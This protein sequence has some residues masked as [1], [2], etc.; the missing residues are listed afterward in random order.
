M[1]AQLEAIAAEYFAPLGSVESRKNHAST[2]TTSSGKAVDR[3][4]KFGMPLGIKLTVDLPW[5]GMSEGHCTY[6]G[7]GDNSAAISLALLGRFHFLPPLLQYFSRIP[8]DD[9]RSHTNCAAPFGI[10][11][12]VQTS[13][14]GSVSM[15]CD[16]MWQRT[17]QFGSD[18]TD[19][20]LTAHRGKRGRRE[21]EKQATLPIGGHVGG[22]GR[23]RPSNKDL[24]IG[25]DS[26]DIFANFS[27]P[28]MSD[29][30]DSYEMLCERHQRGL[31]AITALV[32][33]C[34][35][36]FQRE[37]RG[38]AA[39]ATAGAGF[40]S[41]SRPTPTLTHYRNSIVHSLNNLLRSLT[42][43]GDRVLALHI[44]IRVA[45]WKFSSRN[46]RVTILFNHISACLPTSHS[47][48]ATLAMET[49]AQLHAIG[50]SSSV[51]LK[52]ATELLRLA[53]NFVS[54][55]S[56]PSV[57]ASGYI[58]IR[59]IAQWPDLLY[60]ALLRGM[61]DDLLLATW[62]SLLNDALEPRVRELGAVALRSLFMVDIIQGHYSS[63]REMLHHA[64]SL[65]RTSGTLSKPLGSNVND[66]SD[67]DRAARTLPCLSVGGV[68]RPLEEGKESSS[69][70]PEPN[71]GVAGVSASEKQTNTQN[72]QPVRWIRRVFE[73][74]GSQVRAQSLRG[75]QTPNKAFD[76]VA[77]IQDAAEGL[78]P[79]TTI[80]VTNSV[81][82]N[83]TNGGN[84]FS[85][86]SSVPRT[87]EDFYFGTLLSRHTHGRNTRLD[88]RLGRIRVLCSSSTV[89]HASIL[90][91][92]ALVSALRSCGDSQ[93][94]S[95]AD[96]SDGVLVD[97]ALGGE[98]TRE[99][100]PGDN[101]RS[102]SWSST[103]PKA[104]SSLS[105]VLPSHHS[106]DRPVAPDASLSAQGLQTG[107]EESPYNASLTQVPHCGGRENTRLRG[108]E[109]NPQRPSVQEPALGEGSPTL[110]DRSW[111][112]EEPDLWRLFS[113]RVLLLQCLM[114]AER[115]TEAE[116]LHAARLIPSL[117]F[118]SLH[119]LPKNDVYT[120]LGILLKRV[121]LCYAEH[122]HE[123]QRHDGRTQYPP[124][125]ACRYT[126][127][128]GDKSAM[129]NLAYGEVDIYAMSLINFSL[130]LSAI[131]TTYSQ[132][133][134]YF[135]VNHLYPILF[136]ALQ[137]GS[138]TYCS[139]SNEVFALLVCNIPVKIR[140]RL[141]PIVINLTDIS[142]SMPFSAEM[143]GAVAKICTV[144]RGI[145]THCCFALL[146]RIAEVLKDGDDGPGKDANHFTGRSG[147]D[148]PDPIAVQM[149]KITNL[150]K[151]ILC[152]RVLNAVCTDWES[153]ALF[154]LE[155]CTPYLHHPNVVLRRTCVQSCVRLLLS[156]C[157]LSK[158]EQ[159]GGNP[160]SGAVDD[161][162]EKATSCA[163]HYIHTGVLNAH[164]PLHAA[165]T[166]GYWSER[167]GFTKSG[168][169]IYPF[170]ASAFDN[171]SRPAEAN[172]T[173]GSAW[174]D[175]GSG[176]GS[177]D[178]S[179]THAPEIGSAGAAGHSLM[180]TCERH[181]G[182]SH[183]T[184]L[185]EVLH[186]LVV[187]AL[188]DPDETIRHTALCS[189]TKD[190]DQFLYPHKEVIDLIFS[191]INDE[192]PPSRLEAVRI[193]R[194]LGHYVPMDVY[195]RLRKRFLSM[196][197]D[198]QS[199]SALARVQTA[200]DS[201]QQ[202]ENAECYSNAPNPP[203]QNLKQGANVGSVVGT[204]DS[205]EMSGSAKY[206]A[207]QM[208]LLFELVQSVSPYIST[209]ID[210][211]LKLL[212]QVIVPHDTLERGTVIT[213]LHMIS[214]L[215]DESTR[216]EWPKF[217]VLLKPLSQQLLLRD[218]DVDRL[219]MAISTLQ[220][221]IQYVVIASPFGW[222][223]DLRLT[224]GSLYS[225]LY[226]KPPIGTELSLS[227]VKLLGTISAIDSDYQRDDVQSA[228]LFALATHNVSH[229]SLGVAA[230][231][232]HLPVR[233]LPS[234]I[235]FSQT[236]F[237][238]DCSQD[239]RGVSAQR[240]QLTDHLWPDTIL[241]V[242]LQTL[243]E[244]LDN[245]IA[246]TDEEL[247]A[248][249]QATV[250][251]L[252][253][254]PS[255]AKLQLYMPPLLSVLAGLL[256]RTD[257]DAPLRVS[258][259]ES[260][261]D[262]VKL[263]GRGSAPM[264]GFLVTF[265]NEHFMS[266]SYTLP[267]C[268]R[269]LMAL[270]EAVPD[271][272]RDHC[273]WF[274]SLLLGKLMSH[275]E[276]V[277]LTS[278]DPCALKYKRQQNLSTSAGLGNAH[279]LTVRDTA[280]RSNT[281][282]SAI[283]VVLEAVLALLPIAD[284]FTVHYACLMLSQ[285]LR[286]AGGTP[287]PLGG[288]EGATECHPVGFDYP[289]GLSI[290]VIRDI[291]QVLVD[292]LHNFDLTA[293]AVSVVES[294]LVLLQ[295]YEEG[296]AAALQNVTIELHLGRMLEKS[297]SC[298]YLNNFQRP[299]KT[300]RKR[301]EK[302][303][304]D[305]RGDQQ[306]WFRHSPLSRLVVEE[307][308]ADGKNT[309]HRFPFRD[310]PTAWESPLEMDLL[311][312]V[313]LVTGRCRLPSV[314]YD[315]MI[316]E[317]IETR[318]Q[319]CPMVKK[320]FNMVASPK[321]SLRL[322]PRV[323]EEG[324][325]SAA[326]VA[327]CGMVSAS[328][329]VGGT[330][331]LDSHE[332]RVST[333]AMLERHP[334]EELQRICQSFG[335]REIKGKSFPIP[336]RKIHLP[337]SSRSSL[338]SSPFPIQTTTPKRDSSGFTHKQVLHT[339]EDIAEVAYT[340]N[341]SPVK[342]YVGKNLPTVIVPGSGDDSI[343]DRDARCNCVNEAKP[344]SP[345]A[346]ISPCNG[347]E[348]VK[349][350]EGAPSSVT[351]KPHANNFTP[352]DMGRECEY[353]TENESCDSEKQRFFR[354]HENLSSS[355]WKPW[356][357]M[358][359]T[360]LVENSE[361]TCVSSCTS[362]V[363][364]HFSIFSS[365]ILP[366]AF[367]SHLITCDNAGVEQWMK[368]LCDFAS[369]HT[370]V[371]HPIAGEL[372]RLTYNIRM[373]SASLFSPAMEKLVTRDYITLDLIIKLAEWALDTPLMLICLHEKL[374]A[375]FTWETAARF[376]SALE[377]MGFSCHTHILS[378]KVVFRRAM[379]ELLT[380]SDKNHT[381]GFHT[382][383]L[384]DGA[385]KDLGFTGDIMKQ[386]HKTVFPW[387]VARSG[388][389]TSVTPHTSPKK[390]PSHGTCGAAHAGERRH[391]PPPVVLELGW[392]EAALDGYLRSIYGVLSG[393]NS[394]GNF[395]QVKW[396]APTTG[397]L[398]G[399]ISPFDVV[400][401]MRCYMRV[402]DFESI[403]NLWNTVKKLLF[404]SDTDCCQTDSYTC[405]MGRSLLRTMWP[406]CNRPTITHIAHFVVSAA[407][408]LSRWDIVEG[409]N[410]GDFIPGGIGSNRLESQTYMEF[411]FHK[412]IEI[413][414][415]AALVA[416]KKYA[417]AKVILSSLRAAL[418]DSYAV[419]YTENA[420]LKYELS[421]MFQEISDLE[422]GIDAI[423]LKWAMNNT[424]SDTSCK[425]NPPPCVG[426]VIS[427]ANSVPVSPEPI[428]G[429]RNEFSP[430][431]AAAWD[432]SDLHYWKKKN[433]AYTEATV[434]RLQNI[435]GRILP[436]H[437][438]IV[439]R[440]E[441]ISLRST[442]VPPSWQ[443]QN[444][445]IL[446]ERIAEEGKPRRAVKAIEHFLSVPVSDGGSE[447]DCDYHG[448]LLLER[449][450]IELQHLSLVQDL[451]NL[452]RNVL[453]SLAVI[454]GGTFGL[455]PNPLQFGET[456]AASFVRYLGDVHV[457]QE[458]SELILL[459]MMCQRK[460]A[461]I[462]CQQGNGLYFCTT[463][464][465]PTG[466]CVEQ[467][468]GMHTASRC[469]DGS[470]LRLPFSLASCD[471]PEAERRRYNICYPR[472]VAD[473]IREY[474][475]VE[476][477]IGSPDTAAAVWCEF[478]LLLFDICMAIHKEWATTRESP[479]LNNFC[480]QSKKAISALQKS[481]K[482]WTSAA[483]TSITGVGPYNS[484]SVRRFRHARTALPAVHML[485]KSLHL[486]TKLDEVVSD[487]THQMRSEERGDAGREQATATGGKN[488]DHV[489]GTPC[490]QAKDGGNGSENGDARKATE[491]A[492]AWS[493]D[494]GF[495][496]LDFSPVMYLQWGYVLPF[497]LNAA[498]RYDKLHDAVREMCTHSRAMLYQSVYQLVSTF[499]DS[500]RIAT[501]PSKRLP[502]EDGG[503]I[504]I[505]SHSCASN[506][507]VASCS[508]H[509]WD[510]ASV[511]EESMRRKPNQDSKE[512]RQQEQ[513]LSSALLSE[514]AAVSEEHRT[515]ITQTLRF[516]EFVRGGK[517]SS[518]TLGFCA[519]PVPLWYLQQY[520]S[521]ASVND[522][523]SDKFYAAHKV[524]ADEV[525]CANMQK[526]CG[527]M[528]VSG[529]ELQRVEQVRRHMHS[530]L[531]R[532]QYEEVFVLLLSDGS[533]P[534]FHKIGCA[535]GVKDKRDMPRTGSR[536][537]MHRA[538]TAT[539]RARRASR[540]SRRTSVALFSDTAHY[541]L[542]STDAGACVAAATHDAHPA[543]YSVQL[544]PCL[545]TDHHGQPPCA[546]GGCAYVRPTSA[547]E[548]AISSLLGHLP[549]RHLRRPLVLPLGLHDF[550]TQLPTNAVASPNWQI[551]LPASL[552]AKCIAHLGHQ[553]LSL[554]HILTEYNKCLLAD[555][556]PDEQQH[557]S[558]RGG[559]QTP[560]N[561]T[562]TP[563]TEGRA[564]T[565]ADPSLAG[566]VRQR[567]IAKY[568]RLLANAF[569]EGNAQPLCSY[570][571]NCINSAA[572]EHHPPRPVPH[573]RALCSELEELLR[574]RCGHMR[575]V[576]DELEAPQDNDKSERLTEG[577]SGHHIFSGDTFSAPSPRYAK[578]DVKQRPEDESF[579][580]DVRLILL[581]HE[582]PRYAESLRNVLRVATADASRW[583]SIVQTFTNELAEWSMIQYLLDITNRE[584]TTFFFDAATGHV[585][586][587]VLGKH[588]LQKQKQ[589]KCSGPP[590][591]FPA[592]NNDEGIKE[593]DELMEDE[594]RKL[595]PCSSPFPCTDPAIFRLTGCFLSLM[596]LKCPY[597]V[598]LS[599]ATHC[600]FSILRYQSHL[601]GIVKYGLEDLR[602]VVLAHDQSK[603]DVLL[604]DP[605]QCELQQSRKT[606][607]ERVGTSLGISSARESLNFSLETE[608]S[609]RDSF[610][611][612]SSWVSYCSLDTPTNELATTA[613]Q[614][615][616][617]TFAGAD[618]TA[619]NITSPR[620]GRGPLTRQS[621]VRRRNRVSP[622]DG[623]VKCECIEPFQRAAE[624]PAEGSLTVRTVADA[625]P[626]YRSSSPAFFSVPN[627]SFITQRERL[628]QRSRDLP[629]LFDASSILLKLNDD[630]LPMQ[631]EPTVEPFFEPHRDGMKDL[632]HAL[633]T[634]SSNDCETQD[635]KLHSK[636]S[637][638]LKD[639][640]ESSS[641]KG[642]DGAVPKAGTCRVAK[643]VEDRVMQLIAASTSKENLVGTCATPHFWCT[644]AP[645]W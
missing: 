538:H 333:T 383:G 409:L 344:S 336:M 434:R 32:E 146:Q 141:Q 190:T 629:K 378:N 101:V 311:A 641:E 317:Y 76:A 427:E 298:T 548:C 161:Y 428:S 425:R 86:L 488:G 139:A 79:Q 382:G 73:F 487:G 627:A 607:P 535:A 253:S 463:L 177:A 390:G 545:C 501:R 540:H 614:A 433:V 309:R 117:V 31:M 296:H 12:L 150:N 244:A 54:D 432:P 238:G 461:R 116:A 74:F 203:S 587:H 361:C 599:T 474:R 321:F 144:Y 129:N 561:Q 640:R 451:Q 172:C 588:A 608:T 449:Y 33:K 546:S 367:L 215:M 446:C 72:S 61:K 460:M 11:G 224:V 218:S 205:S 544:P 516:C 430:T 147:E 204:Q 138:A 37:R 356:F 507:A 16:T 52:I 362:L 28:P 25:S 315:L 23:R 402:Y 303:L 568:E 456:D 104:E 509:L 384:L 528:G 531:A 123:Q 34:N 329:S 458:Q 220:K 134:E 113:P 314:S 264:F 128:N 577:S 91:I 616:G 316:R 266:S 541:S 158:A 421:I 185:R 219:H 249:L 291:V 133:F 609:P 532:G 380:S 17:M 593:D 494:V 30:C 57:Q 492:T 595:S 557:K 310:T 462:N 327:R 127:N 40:A 483:Y 556:A 580:R 114:Y 308:C 619:N 98:V 539:C 275:A 526:R 99:G 596:T 598:F 525:G 500:F 368:L 459:Y 562:T 422:E 385:G 348:D 226:R 155:V 170:L 605:H 180:F 389:H 523:K 140:E 508:Q 635:S 62:E 369:M 42:T 13:V 107:S 625:P 406:S 600:L 436:E 22:V 50:A 93:D 426:T 576:D 246:F 183:N 90:V 152:F 2:T 268:C 353:D 69:A 476:H 175:D 200:G 206:S 469:G 543:G 326:P 135:F 343:L 466:F 630:L 594:A 643:T 81:L 301:M 75:T 319:T 639:T 115:G 349:C 196:L 299:S 420:R 283:R 592:A 8:V 328:A 377:D 36:S 408:A 100:V 613:V 585:A 529:V 122:A 337:L 281:L 350:L 431:V 440:L 623:V 340:C 513:S 489:D 581:K 153:A 136:H 323:C 4:K 477:I 270:R 80:G 6:R 578:C 302:N 247:Q 182:R 272:V 339:M 407:K 20:T 167:G 168:T 445:L 415:A 345:L 429:S 188:C 41:R 277:A 120:A 549:V 617:P 78:T 145:K 375:N 45:T 307:V 586:T 169:H 597:G 496:E 263:A 495:A 250:A 77:G 237:S 67:T 26:I 216:V 565:S 173:V 68:Q 499:E 470:D 217:E 374:L 388:G 396:P 360:N 300:N 313:L 341:L 473:I 506:V 269:L 511:A 325:S 563:Q 176:T 47:S 379:Q 628:H 156:D 357:E 551:A 645:H 51:Y 294:A 94:I 351:G 444:I 322:L 137:R 255:P 209:Y 480:I 566:R 151:K 82:N 512:Q 166:R 89:M 157:F 103:E 260:I 550:I 174:S 589:F 358:F 121:N 468:V 560:S 559:H 201:Q 242:L 149:E 318:F 522:E 510:E 223:G 363:R 372:A 295:R 287:G 330:E 55:V 400:G 570:I 457:T 271:L 347:V 465:S 262:L 9:M 187:V 392:S 584:S 401:A 53:R 452:S 213:A 159:L 491:N 391:M 235:R 527:G 424:N 621:S 364:R 5:E 498:A 624:V 484:T 14:Q 354:L 611:Q 448:S 366:I 241:R 603:Y 112:S 285:I 579:L 520:M 542:N 208:M 108:E 96:G 478:G 184:I 284:G 519:L 536:A 306:D 393:V 231:A 442:L 210:P 634:K 7:M 48:T 582:S 418:R 199:H 49:W 376:W 569:D 413:S 234:Y 454:D 230:G 397:E 324:S 292:L 178:Q 109:Q 417:E 502:R 346:L 297:S 633:Y 524:T 386:V 97:I 186:R 518:V 305:H 233:L 273:E 394:Q 18:L 335:D 602:G 632:L 181:A 312:C 105:E 46:E 558:P 591:T 214:Y 251:V 289:G 371:P 416:S 412:Q 10:P 35:N 606:A 437:S 642:G 533:M 211:M 521:M 29:A 485:L 194:R 265:L 257:E 395:G 464:G 24:W 530:S 355:G 398:P 63:L 254:M 553:P 148:V 164:V 142:T 490:A 486:A 620:D 438:T 331:S 60:R 472:S 288:D 126:A 612:I 638:D 381:K 1:A 87:S 110:V 162:M 615:G 225:L 467:M 207:D 601:A 320:F 435:A 423:E 261:T 590:K 304:K 171:S 282:G 71:G 106:I 411:P 189:L 85:H 419:F 475:Q 453:N 517:E 414:R 64:G 245:I 160:L 370:S 481:V 644:W 59:H 19:A 27:Q 555:G 455:G 610:N 21:V 447:G 410:Y 574:H 571:N 637:S 497:L 503:H 267:S 222:R 118:Y 471:A 626:P 515:V 399:K 83:E 193:L 505:R 293:I 195:P 583:L 280:A 479:T 537:S 84:T 102:H 443:L 278:E 243:S 258:T 604:R 191:A 239:D 552:Q 567:Y 334:D 58:I 534:R 439:Q 256:E 202:R 618:V 212:Q 622:Y 547:M 504:D 92:G 111:E 221:L 236:S 405:E 564:S 95:L 290:E 554:F 229:G 514:L 15:Q 573:L 279:E 232:Y 373:Y 365:H 192:Y 88:A 43:R 352:P 575:D 248:C 132:L 240:M 259:M 198:F 65:F 276:S 66:S 124:V 56:T 286:S 38:T 70:A 387:E 441:M 131:A 493:K 39:S 404:S 179:F 119:T 252:R 342:F 359:C 125:S 403:L 274:L 165:K 143:L 227:V 44:I 450:R 163:I 631:Y 197:Y 482:I 572:S 130:L 3:F 228:P 636:S 332:I 154:F 338:L